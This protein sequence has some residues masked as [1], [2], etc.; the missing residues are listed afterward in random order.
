MYIHI[1]ICMRSERIRHEIAETLQGK[2]RWIKPYGYDRKR[3]IPG[4]RSPGGRKFRAGN[5]KKRLAIAPISKRHE[6]IL[7]RD[8]AAF[9]KAL[10][11]GRVSRST[12]A[13]REECSGRKI[14]IFRTR[15]KSWSC[16]RNENFWGIRAFLTSKI[17]LREA[18]GGK[19]LL[20]HVFHLRFVT[21][22]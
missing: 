15:P 6:Y 7:I 22:I 16:V 13:L 5:S 21:R 17:E 14:Q 10:K 11:G 19:T 20:T 9:S 18:H 8:S 1:P 3:L 4:W 2:L 12:L